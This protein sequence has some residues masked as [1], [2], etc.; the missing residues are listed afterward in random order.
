MAAT[1]ELVYA[2]SETALV[3]RMGALDAECGT[4]YPQF[5]DYVSALFERRREWALCL[6]DD[7]PTQGHHTNNVVE[8]AFRV[9][10]DSILHRYA[11]FFFLICL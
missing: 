2:G 10:K 6:R 7:V 5:V 4:T 3:S 9:L 1:K 11:V 8:S